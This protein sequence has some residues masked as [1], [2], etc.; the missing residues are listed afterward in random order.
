MMKP[1]W[2]IGYDGFGTRMVS[3]GLVMAAARLARPSLLPKRRHHLRLRV[4]P[5]VEAAGVIAGERAAQPGNALAGAVAVGARILH[6]LNQLGHDMRR[7]GAVGVAHAE[8]DDVLTRRP[9]P[10]L[11]VVDGGEHVGRQAADAV[12][13]GWRTSIYLDGLLEWSI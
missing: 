4:E 7:G 5:H 3:P 9:R 2:W 6:R 11:G 13:L 8:V 12:E 1:N 10:R